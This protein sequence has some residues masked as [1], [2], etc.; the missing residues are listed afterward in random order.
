MERERSSKKENLYSLGVNK[1]H[2]FSH[3][4][5]QDVVVFRRKTAIY[6]T[7]SC[8]FRLGATT[9]YCALGY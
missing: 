6:G 3:F 1:K 2:G 4:S 5:P 7:T 8:G 9:R